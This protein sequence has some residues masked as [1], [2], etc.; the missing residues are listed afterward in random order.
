MP[1][2][3]V[4]MHKIWF[5]PNQRRRHAYGTVQAG[6]G[7]HLMEAEPGK[8]ADA[9]DSIASISRDSLNEVRAV[10]AALRD[11]EPPYHPAPSLA[12]LPDL[13]EIVRATGLTVE[14]MLP[15]DVESV[16]RQ[17]GA[18]HHTGV[19]DDRPSTCGRLNR[20]RA[21]GPPGWTGRGCHS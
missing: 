20:E 19:P 10:V 7:R 6:V 16:P 9:L 15:D 5:W 13:I 1:K 3:L 11:D 8:A 12:D 14:L 21:G 4:I 2:E 18:A 17:I